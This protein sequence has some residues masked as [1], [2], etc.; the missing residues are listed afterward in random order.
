LKTLINV[1]ECRTFDISLWNFCCC[2]GF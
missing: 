1:F 2:W